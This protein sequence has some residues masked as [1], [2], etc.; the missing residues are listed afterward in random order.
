MG[1]R[2]A[3]LSK[4]GVHCIS[5]DQILIH[6]FMTRNITTIVD[7]LSEVTPYYSRFTPTPA[8]NLLDSKNACF[9]KPRKNQLTLYI[10]IL[11]PARLFPFIVGPRAQTNYGLSRLAVQ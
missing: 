6:T 7:S 8:R 9:R 2:C 3:P 1:A 11:L 5:D 4:K 10:V